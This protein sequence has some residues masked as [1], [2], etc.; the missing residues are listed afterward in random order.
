MGKLTFCS[1]AAELLFIY[2]MLYSSD[3][4]LLGFFERVA[5][6]DFLTNVPPDTAFIVSWMSKA[7]GNVLKFSHRTGQ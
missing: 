5:G 1:D 7:V 2:F 3:N 6:E 4:Q